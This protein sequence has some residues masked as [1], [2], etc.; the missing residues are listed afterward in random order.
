MT[1]G[2]RLGY[3]TVA[4]AALLATAGIVAIILGASGIG[5]ENDGE[6][7]GATVVGVIALFGT[8]GLAMQVQ[9]PL[10]GGV[11][12][13]LGSIAAALLNSWLILPVLI[14]PITLVVVIMR[15]RRLAGNNH[16]GLAHRG[17]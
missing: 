5:I 16:A 11:L 7:I 4:I 14:V 15:A 13:V 3:V 8:A 9:R 6:R 1:P 17:I 2:G 12:A 10:L